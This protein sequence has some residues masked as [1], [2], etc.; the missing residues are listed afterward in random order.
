MHKFIENP[1]SRPQPIAQTALARAQCSEIFTGD[2]QHVV[3]Q[4]DLESTGIA[5]CNCDV[6]IDP[7]IYESLNASGRGRNRGCGR[8][9]HACCGEAVDKCCS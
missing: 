3:E 5:A 8:S 6:Q 4:L 7:W 2:R 9:G 1:P